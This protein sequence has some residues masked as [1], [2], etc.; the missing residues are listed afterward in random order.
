[1]S[2]EENLPEGWVWTTL[3]NIVMVNPSTDVSILPASTLVSFV[4][5]V[6]VGAGTGR[7]DSSIIRELDKV[8]K[9]YTAFQEGDVLFAKITPCMEN[10]KFAVA[11][12]LSS[13]IGFGST[14]FHVLRPEDG[15]NPHLIYCYLS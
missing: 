4:P 15:I 14:E 1:V 6:A 13:S 9:G 12:L 8:K 10:G 11:Q 7:M 3:G 5:M 2:T